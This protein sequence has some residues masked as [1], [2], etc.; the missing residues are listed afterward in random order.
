MAECTHRLWAFP[1]N[2]R[3]VDQILLLPQMRPGGHYP[4]TYGN[5]LSFQQQALEF[6]GIPSDR[7]TLI[8]ETMQVEE[9][10]VPE[11][12]ACLQMPFDLDRDYLDYLSQNEARFFQSYRPMRSQYPEKVYV[13]RAAFLHEGGIAGEQY[14]QSQLEAEGYA[15]V[16]PQQLSLFEQ[17]NHYRHARCCIFAEGSAVH[18]LQL[19]GRL[20]PEAT[21]VLISRRP[22]NLTEFTQVIAPRIGRTLTFTQAR[23]LPP[24]DQDF[25]AQ[26]M[27]LARALSLVNSAALVEFLRKSGVATLPGFSFSRFRQ[28]ETADVARYLVRAP[29]DHAAPD[30]FLNNFRRFQAEVSEARTSAIDPERSTRPAASQF[31]KGG[32]GRVIT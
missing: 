26:R 14:L 17:L 31:A 15:V 10:L 7:V 29:I 6:M 32:P 20:S 22:R 12:A 5:L 3:N 23:P 18:A 4:D 27:A 25:N 30:I 28:H 21:F 16:R 13:S 24:L 2:A 9:L 19:L 8:K 11:P 1:P